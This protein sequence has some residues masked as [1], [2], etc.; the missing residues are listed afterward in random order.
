MPEVEGGCAVPLTPTGW[1]VDTN[2]YAAVRQLIPGGGE[3][4]I[5]PTASGQL[6]YGVGARKSPAILALLLARKRAVLTGQVAWP[7]AG[8]MRKSRTKRTAR[9]GRSTAGW[10]MAAAVGR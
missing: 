10:S 6:L 7:G 5:C 1:E 2:G 8:V 9:S 3:L 4:H